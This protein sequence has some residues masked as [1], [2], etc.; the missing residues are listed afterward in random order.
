MVVIYIGFS[1]G[2]VLGPS[3][4]VQRDVVLFLERNFFFRFLAD[5][6]RGIEGDGAIVGPTDSTY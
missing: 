2:W 6:E 5:P 1:M 3:V 4:D